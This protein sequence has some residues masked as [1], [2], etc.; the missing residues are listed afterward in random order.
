MY[1]SDAIAAHH[2]EVKAENIGAIDDAT[3]IDIILDDT[4][5]AIV[6]RIAVRQFADV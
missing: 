2:E 5:L 1:S 4:P 6:M 3:S